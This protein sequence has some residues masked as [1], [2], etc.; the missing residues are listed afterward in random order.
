MGLQDTDATL[1]KWA[2]QNEF[3]THER[4]NYMLKQCLVLFPALGPNLLRG[5]RHHPSRGAM[6]QRLQKKHQGRNAI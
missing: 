5:G 4:R 3:H 6:F 2:L 1:R